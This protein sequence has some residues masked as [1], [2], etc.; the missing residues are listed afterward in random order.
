MDPLLNTLLII[1]ALA[2]FGL[3][4]YIW[5][6]KHQKRPMVCPLKSDCEA[7]INSQY[8]KFFGV[9]VEMIGLFYYGI[10]AASYFFF[11]AT[12]FSAN[13]LVVFLVLA[14]STLAVLFSLYLTFIQIF[15]IRQWCFWCLT[16]ASICIAIFV[17]A[18]LGSGFGFV[19]LLVQYY[20]IFVILH[21]LGMALGLGS[22]ILVDI[23]FYKFLE[24]SQVSEFED[25]VM[26]ILSQ[27]IWAALAI[28]VTTGLCFYIARFPELNQNPKFLAKMV[29]VLVI[30]VNGALLNLLVAP[31]MKKI[32]FKEKDD[33]ATGK[34]HGLRKLAFAMGAISMTSWLSAFLLGM[35]RSLDFGFLPIIS[36]YFGVV[37]VAVISSQVLERYY[38]SRA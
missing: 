13:S 30:I 35:I 15:S 10:I 18:V 14:A 37:I 36:V 11:L 23:F 4:F 28:L 34:S 5:N 29:V 6:K 9:P 17:L 22:V 1:F 21:V 26:H 20:N 33:S 16:S 27:V 38:A 3:A 12:P 25:G 31:H 24:D 7:V 2:G 19:P 32:Q 8:S